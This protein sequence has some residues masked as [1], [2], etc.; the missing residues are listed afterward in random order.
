MYY[1]FSVVIES[2][3]FNLVLNEIFTYIYSKKKKE[4]CFI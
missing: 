2:L 3:L 4:K 1:K